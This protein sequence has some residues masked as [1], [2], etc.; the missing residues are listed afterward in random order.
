MKFIKLSFVCLLIL[1]TSKLFAQVPAIQV[2]N[3]KG[4]KINTSKM[5]DNETP[6][7]VSFWSTTCKPCFSEL[8]AISEQMPDWLDVLN[9]RLFAI[10]PDDSRSSYKSKSFLYCLW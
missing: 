1:I 2:E 5:I 6:F 8:Y 3:S 7:I 10:S 4:E 9:F